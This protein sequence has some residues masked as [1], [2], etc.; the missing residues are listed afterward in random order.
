M[1]KTPWRWTKP[2]P[3]EPLEEE[4]GDIKRTFIPLQA[5]IKLVMKA[6]RLVRAEKCMS[7]RAFCRLYDVQPSQLRP[8]EK[9]IITMKKTLENTIWYVYNTLTA[10]HIE[11]LIM[12]KKQLGFTWPAVFAWFEE[13]RGGL[14]VKQIHSH[15]YRPSSFEEIFLLQRRFEN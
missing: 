2:P 4:E 9:N 13:G 3:L 1:E 6:E 14:P 12:P 15:Q 8:W 10:R 5:K 7:Y 11:D